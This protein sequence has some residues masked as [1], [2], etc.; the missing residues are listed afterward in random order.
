MGVVVL[1]VAT[2]LMFGLLYLAYKIVASGR[3]DT[4]YVVDNHIYFRSNKD[5]DE[6]APLNLKFKI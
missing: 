3:Y 1:V 4:E 6:T 5:N 2:I